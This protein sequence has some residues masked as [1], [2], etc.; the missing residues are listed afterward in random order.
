MEAVLLEPAPV[1][2]PHPWRWAQ[3]HTAA[4]SC[5]G[6]STAL[7]DGPGA[8]QCL[9]FHLFNLISLP[10][11]GL[12][13]H[14][15]DSDC[16]RGGQGWRGCQACRWLLSA[17]A[18]LCNLRKRRAVLPSFSPLNSASAEAAFDQIITKPSPG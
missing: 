3:L 2:S 14:P 11:P 5:K 17:A 12:T 9:F 16:L 4:H 7:Q 6:P 8:N 15:R 1:L 10:K 13:G 18:L